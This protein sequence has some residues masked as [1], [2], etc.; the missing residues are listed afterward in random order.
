MAFIPL[1]ANLYARL[2]SYDCLVA[3]SKGGT[4]ESHSPSMELFVKCTDAKQC[5]GLQ[6]HETVV[7]RLDNEQ[8]TFR[9]LLRMSM[10]E[11][12]RF[13]DLRPLHESL[14]YYYT[15]IYPRHNKF[16]SMFEQSYSNNTTFAG[17]V[18]MQPSAPMMTD[19]QNSNSVCVPHYSP[20]STFSCNL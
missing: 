7:L 4:Y 19:P 10:S 20:D 5:R 12:G 8:C 15:V 18:S 11:V 2:W 1:S 9:L 3:A 17:S 13:W 16:P 14:N 6:P